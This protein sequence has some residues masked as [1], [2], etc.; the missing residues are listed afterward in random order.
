MKDRL[1]LLLATFV[2]YIPLLAIQKPLFMAYNHNMAETTWQDWFAVIR[3]G[4]SLDMTIAG[5]L[6]IIPFLIILLSV[7]IKA[8]WRA[9]LKVYFLISAVLVATIF[10]VDIALYAYWGF[11][12]D[13]TVLF[14]LESPKDAMASIPV[15]QFIQQALFFIAY[16]TLI[17][18]VCWRWVVPIFKEKV[19]KRI[20]STGVL[21]FCGAL[22][23]LPIRGGVTVS[24]ANVGQVY[25]SPTLFLNHAAINPCFSLIASV[26]KEQDFASQYNYLS[27]ADRKET[28]TALTTKP[29]I[30]NRDTVLNTTRPNILLILLESFSAN[31]VGVLGG[32]GDATPQL[33]R[34][35]KSGILFT[36][37]YANSFRT[38]RGIVSTLNG[39]PAQ[40]TTSIMKYPAKSQS[41]PALAT[42]LNKN[43]YQ[44][45]MLYGG[46][47]NFTN[48]QSYFYASGYEKIV[49]DSDF[50]L[51]SRLSKWG[52]NDDMTF[53][54]LFKEIKQSDATQPWFKTFLTLSSHEPF[55]VPY[56]HY[57]DPYLNSVA[58]T[59]SCIGSFIDSLEQLPSWKNTLVILVSDH[60]FLYPDTIKQYAPE[61]HHIPMIWLGG[62]IKK[63][64]VINTLA[65]QNDIVATV[66]NQLSLDSSAFAFSKDIFDS[67]QDKYVF[68]SFNNGFGWID[69]TGTSVFNAENEAPLIES[70]TEGSSLRIHKGKAYLQTL[71]DDMGSR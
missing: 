25:F 50:P 58:Y 3:H 55:E 2:A 56:A 59:D 24:T 19:T 47:I 48:M 12:L 5:Y 26:L 37:M 54:H 21:L 61:R 51:S 67:Q 31:A 33:D 22:L 7:W 8:P 66:L 62:A 30:A 63:P 70:P 16:T 39:Y 35:S 40:P 13:S 68:Y 9:V 49:A 71:Y 38:D 45:S 15:V 1:L 43:G 46:D 53:P 32:E 57:E 44:S 14:Y 36:Q 69:S 52:V 27:E 41:L 23:I 20:L 11:R 4:I 42:A 65:S 64:T 28:F 10:S 60:G 6:S 18:W 29:A 17:T 34:L